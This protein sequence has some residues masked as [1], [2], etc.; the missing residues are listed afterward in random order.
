MC[1]GVNFLIGTTLQ[2]VRLELAKE[3]ATRG[4][5][6]SLPRHEVSMAS[7]LL[8]GFE[9]EDSQC[10]DYLLILL[11]T[12]NVHIDTFCFRKQPRKRV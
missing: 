4:A 10:V 6:G 2:D 8:T 9:L 1:Y 11:I 12:S 3:E 5:L 7:F